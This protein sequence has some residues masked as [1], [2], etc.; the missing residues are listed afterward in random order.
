MPDPALW[1]VVDQT[2]G[3]VDSVLLGDQSDDE[4]RV[5]LTVLHNGEDGPEVDASVLYPCRE[6][7]WASACAGGEGCHS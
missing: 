1:R 5:G 4:F 2:T 6:C 7:G 3:S